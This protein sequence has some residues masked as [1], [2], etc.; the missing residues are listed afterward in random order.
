MGRAVR[1]HRLDNRTAR[2]K[3]PIRSEPYWRSINEGAHMGYYRG[4]RVGKWVARFRKRGSSSGYAKITLGEA[5]DSAD[6]D[7]ERIL[8]FKQ[9]Q[10]R[11]RAWFEVRA[12]GG[13]RRGPFTVG[14]ALDAYLERFRGKSLYST[15]KRVESAI[16]PHL[17][18]I[19]V[20][21]LTP[22]IIREWHEARAS[23]AAQLRTGSKASQPNI[24]PVV[25]D[26]A[27][28]RRRSTAN[29][30]LTVLKAALN[31]AADDRD[32][33]PIEAWRRV[34]PFEKVDVAKRRYLGEAEARRLV[35]ACALDFRPLVQAALLTGA[36]YGEL[37]KA[38]VSDFNRESRT[39][40][41][42]DTKS[43]QPRAVYLDEEGA[44]LFEGITV[45]APTDRLIFTRPDGEPWRASQQA[46]PIAAACKTAKLDSIGFHDLR[47]SYGA[48]L[49]LRGVPLAVI[50][51]AMGHAD[52]RI[53]RKHY[54]HLSPSYVSDTVRA[55]I[56]GLGIVKQGNVE[57][58][59]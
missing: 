55:G 38:K 2:L 19:E 24:R 56:A 54:A 57:R 53:T 30:D 8:D 11:A 37:T 42:A 31:R 6:A 21:A 22:S 39:L 27:I 52:E 46:R 59:A 4:T 35:N 43:G 12:C 17:G 48:R 16:R 3:L 36:R 40:W 58:I 44:R 51:E 9:A 18:S 32:D 7:G 34:K 13:R 26:E 33:L 49:A 28:R 23:S 10:D 47:R 41:L 45:G 20:A 25:G 1:D 29:R 5:D 14:D 50:A 15:R